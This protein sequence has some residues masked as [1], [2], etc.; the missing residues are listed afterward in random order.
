MS[1]TSDY[2][3]EAEERAWN[4]GWK[5]CREA[6]REAFIPLVGTVQVDEILAAIEPPAMASALE[7]PVAQVPAPVAESAPPRVREPEHGN[8]S[9]EDAGGNGPAGRFESRATGAA[10]AIGQQR[11]SDIATWGV[12]ADDA[13]FSLPSR[14]AGA[15]PAQEPVD[16][17]AAVR[18]KHMH[19]CA[20]AAQEEHPRCKC[21]CGATKP[22]QEYMVDA[23]WGAAPALSDCLDCGMPYGGDDWLDCV[24]PRWQ[25]LEINPDDGG[26]LCANCMVKRASKL[27][28][29]VGFHAVIGISPRAAPPEAKESK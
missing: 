28:G 26:I 23:K 18:R 2:Q 3:D 5:A 7:A 11:M 22:N 19:E 21:E 9:P 12:A 24:L 13:T 8:E 27:P 20:I 29:V 6:I 10:P 14:P 16:N 1:V 17:R 25:W 15:A 4:N